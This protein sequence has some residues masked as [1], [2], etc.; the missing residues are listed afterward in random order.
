MRVTTASL[1]LAA[2]FGLSL[3]GKTLG[4]TRPASSDADQGADI[5]SF[6]EERGLTVHPPDLRTAPVWIVG[7]RGECRVRVADVA[8][9]GWSQAIVSEQTAGERLAYA[10]AGRF[11]AEQPVTSTRLE[12]YRRR[13]IRYLGFRAP[14]LRLRAVAASPDCPSDILRPQDASRLS[15]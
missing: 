6:L 1:L 11:H 5:V 10:F 12:N 14:E 13:L 9:E 4:L 3:A 7:T 8:P 2:L 15:N